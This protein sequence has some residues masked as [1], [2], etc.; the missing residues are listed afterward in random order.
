MRL[1]I[2][3]PQSR[4]T[5][6]VVGVEC[7]MTDDYDHQRHTAQ[8]QRKMIWHTD[9]RSM[10]KWR[11]IITRN[12]DTKCWLEPTWSDNKVKYGEFVTEGQTHI[13]PPQTGRGGS[14]FRGQYKQYKQAR[15]DKVL[16]FAKFKNV[17]DATAVAA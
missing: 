9:G 13:A 4:A 1:V 16:Q 12:D 6:V 5:N 7:A 2:Q 8:K 11:F 3:G 10:N 17:P 15:V 14:D